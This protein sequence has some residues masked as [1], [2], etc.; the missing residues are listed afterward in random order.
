M[1]NKKDI[2]TKKNKKERNDST[3]TGN[4]LIGFFKSETTH[5]AIGL[6]FLIIAVYLLLVFT[7]FFFTGAADQS[8][9]ENPVENINQASRV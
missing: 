9:V 7:S 2:S 5:F 4:S 8:I 1:A 6:I 3:Q